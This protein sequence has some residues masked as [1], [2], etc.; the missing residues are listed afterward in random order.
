[1]KKEPLENV[2][3]AE[4]RKIL[5]ELR[6]V[7]V[8]KQRIIGII[9]AGIIVTS[10]VVGMWYWERG[11]ESEDFTFAYQ[12]RV[13]DAASIIAV[14]KGFFEDEGLSVKT[15]RFSSGPACTEA[16]VYGNAE[17]GTMG[18]TTG[19]IT[20]SQGHPVKII[21]SH[22]GG[23]HR[24]RI[25]VSETSNIETI[26]DLE[27]KRIGV[28]KGTSTHGGF[29]LFAEKYGLDLENEIVDMRPS[30][31]LTALAAGELDAIV[32][33]EPTPS[34]AIAN[35]YGRELV[36]LGGLNNTYPILI[37]VH[38]QFT[39]EHPETVVKML[40]ALIR[41]TDFI[42]NNLDEA[43]N[44][45]ATITGLDAEVVKNAMS[46]HY[47]NVCMVQE[48]KDS[49]AN[50]A[51][52]LKNMG[53]I[54]EIPD[55]NTVIETSYLEEALTTYNLEAKSNNGVNNDTP[56]VLTILEETIYEFIK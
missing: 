55:F 53:Q 30:D 11:E 35:G 38:T 19:I 17:F 31:Q 48:T 47:Y 29:L 37:L 44:I 34:L 41:A 3:R 14:E 42:Q 8:K 6:K 22:G 23:E 15:M 7:K 1:M 20:T 24:H 13:A 54:S 39:H 2:S 28:K 10:I 40:R 27:G 43:A 45:Q 16:L 18:D 26:G 25:I 51:T 33:S 50:M 56:K 52:F 32:A 46:F 21:C 4:K 49:L 12:D 9:V 36:T 5:E